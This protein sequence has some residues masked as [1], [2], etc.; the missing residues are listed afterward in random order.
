[1]YVSNSERDIG[2]TL[3][4]GEGSSLLERLGNVFHTCYVAMRNKA[5]DVNC[6]GAWASAGIEN[7]RG[8]V[9]C[10]VDC[11]LVSHLDYFPVICDANLYNQNFNTRQ[12]L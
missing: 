1:M 2:Y 12:R 6:N 9:V 7:D 8:G 3:G 10:C 5:S 4:Q 11:G